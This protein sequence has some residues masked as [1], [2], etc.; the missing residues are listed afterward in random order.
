MSSEVEQRMEKS[1]RCYMENFRYFQNEKLLVGSGGD[2]QGTDQ[3]SGSRK[4][5]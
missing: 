2:A 4:I 5:T 3:I 1:I